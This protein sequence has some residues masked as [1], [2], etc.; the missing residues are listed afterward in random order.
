MCCLAELIR[1]RVVAIP[2][3]SPLWVKRCVFSQFPGGPLS[4]VVPI[5]DKHGHGSFVREVPIGDIETSRLARQE[6]HR[7]A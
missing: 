5:G 7:N 3:L 2:I 1:L 4:V 6:S